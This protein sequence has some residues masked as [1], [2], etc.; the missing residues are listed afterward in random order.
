MVRIGWRNQARTATPW[1]VRHGLLRGPPAHA[2]SCA[3]R[4]LFLRFF[5]DSVRVMSGVVC[6]IYMAF[7]ITYKRS[8]YKSKRKK[9][10]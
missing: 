4:I 3:D 2:L 6:A 9:K 5:I 7:L 8:I 1:W 10:K